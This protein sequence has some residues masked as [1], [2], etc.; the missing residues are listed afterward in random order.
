MGGCFFLMPNSSGK[1]YPNLANT[2]GFLT[3]RG[4]PIPN[5]TQ[6]NLAIC[7]K[8]SKILLLMFLYFFW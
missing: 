1:L 3:L 5:I 4:Y 7:G 8:T 2:F 6:P